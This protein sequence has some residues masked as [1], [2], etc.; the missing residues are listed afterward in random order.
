MEKQSIREFYERNMY[1]TWREGEKA[2]EQTGVLMAWA[3]GT[4][5][6][7]DAVYAGLV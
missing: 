1:G 2:E 6:V 7:L 5:K 4:S 3:W